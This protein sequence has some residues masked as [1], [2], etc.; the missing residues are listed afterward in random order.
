[1]CENGEVKE[2][3]VYFRCCLVC[4]K[5][6]E[7]FFCLAPFLLRAGMP[8]ELCTP[9][10]CLHHLSLLLAQRAGSGMAACRQRAAVVMTTT[11]P[12]QATFQSEASGV[13]AGWAG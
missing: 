10:P 8:Q 9:L 6:C 12:P 11:N 7:L 1:M 5:L 3:K 4:V 2:K 13:R